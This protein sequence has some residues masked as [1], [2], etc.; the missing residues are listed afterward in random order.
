ML[1]LWYNYNYKDVKL[2][3]KKKKWQTITTQPYQWFNRALNQFTDAL[4]TLASM[5][6][7]PKGVDTTF[8]DWTK[9]WEVQINI[10][11]C[12]RFIDIVGNRILIGEVL[13]P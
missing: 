3:I 10:E 13:R 4:V 9:L 12:W 2:F 7:I 5:D 6:E 8:E 1:S 11:N